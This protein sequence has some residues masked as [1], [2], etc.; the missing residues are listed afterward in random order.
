MTKRQRPPIK[1]VQRRLGALGR[2]GIKIEGS[3]RFLRTALG[4]GLA[5]FFNSNQRDIANTLRRFEK[6]G[7]SD[8]LDPP[9][10]TEDHG[11]KLVDVTARICT[12]LGAKAASIELFDKDFSPSWSKFGKPEADA[13]FLTNFAF[14]YAK[15][16]D[17]SADL[18]WRLSWALA[19]GRLMEWRRYWRREQGASSDERPLGGVGS[20]TR[21]NI[22]VRKPQDHETTT[23]MVDLRRD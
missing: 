21:P 13:W 4:D 7:L 22:E 14:F 23:G 17:P 9:T 16:N 6:L 2:K 10:E 8:L 19:L 1:L 5:L 12:A 20:S 18:D 3:K 15:Q 11:S